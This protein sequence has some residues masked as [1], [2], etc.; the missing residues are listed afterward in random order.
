M[1]DDKKKK[2]ELD[3]SDLENVAGGAG[4]RGGGTPKIKIDGGGAMS[5]GVAGAD[6]PA[7]RCG[8]AFQCDA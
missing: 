5:P 7:A 4:R 3:D 2:E 6:A 1:S 8:M